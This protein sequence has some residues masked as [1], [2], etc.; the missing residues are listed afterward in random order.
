[1]EENAYQN[2]RRKSEKSAPGFKAAKDRLT[3]LFCV[4]ASGHMI[5]PVIVYKL[6]NPCTLKGKN[7]EHLLVYWKANKE[8]WVTASLFTEWFHNC[9]LREVELY[10]ASKSL[11]FRVVLLIDNAPGLPENV[12]FD[13]LNVEILFL[14]PN[15]SL[16]QLLDQG[17]IAAFK[18]YYISRTFTSLQ[19]EMEKG[20]SLTVSQS[21]KNYNIA[22]CL[23]NIKESVE[24]VKESNIN[25]CWWKLWPEVVN[26][27]RISNMND[28]VAEIVTIAKG[29]E[30]EGFENIETTNIQEL[31]ESH[32]DEL[33]IE[34]LDELV[35]RSSENQNDPED[36]VPDVVRSE[37]N[38]KPLNEMFTLSRQLSDKVFELDP[39]MERSIKFKRELDHLL[40]PYKEIHK[41]LE[42]KKKQ[43]SNKNCF[44]SLNTRH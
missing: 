34:K 12:M 43:T 28:M 26:D 6:L 1:L 21:W 2:L 29:M 4:N 31:P 7:K 8:A 3:L 10:L 9:F 14:P 18:T 44:V 13:H 22:V 11:P 40:A 38:N 20:S 5:K 25:T 37:F 24:E 23:I 30:G 19:N 42:K 27:R 39:N 41:E 36:E 32:A 15:T 35:T 33:T 16:L 17:V